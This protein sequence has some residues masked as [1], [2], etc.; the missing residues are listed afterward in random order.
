MQLPG[1]SFK[2]VQCAAEISMF[3]PATY[4]KLCQRQKL[5]YVYSYW[6]SWQPRFPAM[7]RLG[8]GL[9]CVF[10]R[11]F[12]LGQDI[13]QPDGFDWDDNKE[14]GA[15]TGGRK[16]EAGLAYIMSRGQETKQRHHL[17]LRLQIFTKSIE[18]SIDLLFDIHSCMSNSQDG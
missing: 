2:K 18:K 7:K 3:L 13:F 5:Q 17:K 6:I 9:V 4:L 12:F 8:V 11:F 10:R 1:Q 15:G 14:A 16:Y